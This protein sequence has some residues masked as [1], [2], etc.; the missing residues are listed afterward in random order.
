MKIRPQILMSILLLCAVGGYALTL[1]YV[2]VATACIGGVIAL[3][4][5][6]L[7]NE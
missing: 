4:M 7:E 1:D 2:E 6:L 5:K 3:S